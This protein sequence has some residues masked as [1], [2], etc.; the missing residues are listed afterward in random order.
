MKH[1]KVE[2]VR[3]GFDVSQI[4]D[5]V[6]VVDVPNHTYKAL[7]TLNYSNVISSRL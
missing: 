1:R 3:E 4:D 5:P 7:T 6:F 2:L